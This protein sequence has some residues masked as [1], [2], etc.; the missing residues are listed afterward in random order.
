MNNIVISS[1]EKPTHKLLAFVVDEELL[2]LEAPVVA[3][4]ERAVSLLGLAHEAAP[5]VQVPG[6]GRRSR[7][8]QDV[9]T[10]HTETPGGGRGELGRCLYERT[11]VCEIGRA[12]CRERV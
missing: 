3:A 1:N 6:A 4:C 9:Q 12:S 7:A 2:Q 10:V 11:C 8:H 5:R